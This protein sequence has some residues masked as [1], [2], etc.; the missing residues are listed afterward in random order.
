MVLYEHMKQLEPLISSRLDYK[1]GD[2][3]A[4]IYLA[5]LC[6]N[7]LNAV[8]FDLVFLGPFSLLQVSSWEL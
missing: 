6:R 7:G 3:Q 5:I 1:H 2:D 4:Y 8:S